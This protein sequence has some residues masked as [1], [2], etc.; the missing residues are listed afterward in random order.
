MSLNLQ[1]DEIKKTVNAMLDDLSATVSSQTAAENIDLRYKIG[2]LRAYYETEI[3][4]GDFAASLLDCFTTAR[5]DNGRLIAFGQLRE[6]LFAATPKGDISLAIV[7]MG[8]VYC[9]SAESRIISEMTFVSRND[10]DLMIDK[11]KTAF[12]TARELVADAADSSAYRALIQ[13]S[14]ALT[15]HLAN[16]SRPLPRMVTFDMRV[17][18]PALTL[19]NRVYHDPTR[20]EEICDENKIVH[21][22][23]CPM[24]IVGLSS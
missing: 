5:E 16:V 23:F 18:L 10:V 3:A 12:D 11:M 1:K 24:S 20:W 17:V 4:D 6:N 22:A 8:I 9:L 21:P 13:L 2:D 14:G 15:N 19:S 7:Q